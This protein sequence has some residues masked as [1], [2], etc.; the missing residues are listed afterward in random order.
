ME[1]YP[2]HICDGLCSLVA[3]VVSFKVELFDGGDFLPEIERKDTVSGGAANSAQNA[4]KVFVGGGSMW[5]PIFRI[6]R[7]RRN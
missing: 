6:Q 3:D 2:E 7:Q 1:S 4:S 5:V